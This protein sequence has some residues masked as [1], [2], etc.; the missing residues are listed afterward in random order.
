MKS[1]KL[2]STSLFMIA[3]VLIAA[4]VPAAPAAQDTPTP[5]TPATAAGES[6]STPTAAETGAATAGTPAV[7][8]TGGTPS[9]TGTPE[10]ALTVLVGA[11]QGSETLNAFYPMAIRVPAGESVTW[12]QNSDE[13][14]TVTFLGGEA[15]PA[16]VEAAPGGQAGAM[17]INPN[18]AFS[19]RQPGG[20]V[21]A[22][23]GTTYV[24]SGIMSPVPTTPGAPIN[25]TFTLNFDTPGVY[26]YVCL[27]HGPGM[28][29]TVTVDPATSTEAM[30]ASEVESQAQEEIHAGLASLAAVR[31]QAQTALSEIGPNGTTLW[32]VRAGLSDFI[33]GNLQAELLEFAPSDLTV[34]AGDTVIWGSNSFHTVTFLPNG[35]PLEFI[36][37]SPQPG[38]PPELLLNPQVLAPAKPAATYAPGQYYNSGVIGSAGPVG[39]S[40]ALTFD[41]PG[42]YNYICVV[43][44]P[45]GMVGTITVEP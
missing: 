8:E 25:D 42:T 4:C 18:A 6:V 15:Y 22:Y 27:V 35:E 13:I 33:T 19:T 39:E 26:T 34:K 37:P 36:V 23:S 1:R 3:A 43:H 31:Q 11:G 14:H 16:F 45:Q 5:G 20:A 2:H 29:G 28:S 9:G 41:T 7:P 40:W 10:A 30:T 24:N 32:H 12:Q 44:L 21:E 17:R 38:G